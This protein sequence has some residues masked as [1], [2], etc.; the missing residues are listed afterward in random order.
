MKTFAS[1][2][3]IPIGL[4][5]F[6]IILIASG[7]A[8]ASDAIELPDGSKIDMSKPCPVCEMKITSGPNGPAAVVFADGNVV[9][10]DANSDFFKYL[11]DPEKY[12]VSKSSIKSR[13]VKANDKKQFIEATNAFF[14]IAAGDSGEMGLEITAYQDRSEAEKFVKTKADSRILGFNEITLQDVQPKKK[15]LKMKETTS[16]KPK[17]RNSHGGH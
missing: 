9:A 3:A 1:S 12:N 13:F 7:L 15:M 6:A 16:D 14:V 4:V 17:A 10:F 8:H 11:L 5:M 2:V